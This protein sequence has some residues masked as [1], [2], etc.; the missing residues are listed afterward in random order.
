MKNKQTTKSQKQGSAHPGNAS[1]KKQ[2]RGAEAKQSEPT[3]LGPVLS[4]DE[5]EALLSARPEIGEE[6]KE[7]M[8][9]LVEAVRREPI[10]REKVG[11]N[12]YALWG[13]GGE[14][15]PATWDGILGNIL[16]LPPGEATNLAL[17]YED[18][19]SGKAQQNGPTDPVTGGAETGA[20]GSTLGHS[21]PAE[22]G[23]QS[24]GSPEKAEHAKSLSAEGDQSSTGVP[25]D[26]NSEPPT[27]PVEEAT[28][29]VLDPG[30]Q[31]EGKVAPRT[32]KA[33][34]APNTKDSDEKPLSEQERNMLE[35]CQNVVFK[36][37]ATFVEVGSAIA[38][39]ITHKL[40]RETHDRFEDYAEEV[41]G[42]SARRAYQL[43]DA[44]EVTGN[45][46]NVNSCSQ[47]D[48]ANVDL[49]V[50]TNENQVRRLK[51]F[52]P[53][54]QRKL[55]QAAVEAANGKQVTAKLL[56]EII[57]TRKTAAGTGAGHSANST[58]TQ[59]AQTDPKKLKKVIERL[60]RT[61]E[62]WKESDRQVLVDEIA[63]W[64]KRHSGEAQGHS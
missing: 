33:P 29:T 9:S 15:E 27:G 28:L 52:G 42:L 23:S 4:R 47:A 54:M 56:D 30:G 40:Y 34:P 2:Q 22:S 6:L 45:L 16:G 32:E 17:L 21:S 5:I 12:Y 55:W 64:L 26:A 49:P 39:I 19:C 36:G 59:D 10:D 13:L 25:A 7:R 11:G 18:Q 31:K 1:R 14:I 48:G 60:N 50:P 61:W 51:R 62:E 37:F 43:R 58:G 8:L 20:F 3:Q 41:L 44:S 24:S 63:A 35:N 53:D 38:T 46:K 57:T